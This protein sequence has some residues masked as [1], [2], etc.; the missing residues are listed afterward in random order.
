MRHPPPHAPESDTM[1]GSPNRHIVTDALGRRPIARSILT[2]VEVPWMRTR[3]LCPR[4]S[5]LSGMDSLGSTAVAASSRLGW[6]GMFSTMDSCIRCVDQYSTDRS[7]IE[8]E[9]QEDSFKSRYWRKNGGRR[10]VQGALD[11]CKLNAVSAAPDREIDL[12][13]E[14]EELRWVPSDPLKEHL[15]ELRVPGIP[16]RRRIPDPPPEQFERRDLRVPEHPLIPTRRGE[17][18]IPLLCID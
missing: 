3:P 18:R 15:G 5:R 4:A 11:R 8:T 6:S 10:L 1:Q 13:A 7:P 17:I 9:S 12:T 16:S 2:S 14:S